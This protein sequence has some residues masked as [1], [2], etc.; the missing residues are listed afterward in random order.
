MTSDL[1]ATTDDLLN[2]I[3]ELWQRAQGGDELAPPEGFGQAVTS[4]KDT[5]IAEATGLELDPVREYLDNADGTQ[6]VVGRDG[7]TRAVQ[8]L[9]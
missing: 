9:I 4:V 8:G 6:L 7:D 3:R 1:E 5:E 2:T